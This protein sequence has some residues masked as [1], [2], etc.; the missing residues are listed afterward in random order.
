MRV[1]ARAFEPGEL[2]KGGYQ[3]TW[4]FDGNHA[5]AKNSP[6]QGDGKKVF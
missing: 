5:D 3:S 6:T 2:P 1:V 4:C